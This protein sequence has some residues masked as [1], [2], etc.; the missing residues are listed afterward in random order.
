MVSQVCPDQ[1]RLAG[2]VQGLLTHQESH[3]L[4]HHLQ[5]CNACGD[6]VREL[7]A[8]DTVLKYVRTLDIDDKLEDHD[9]PKI[10]SLL[11][12]L[13][14]LPSEKNSSRSE[15]SSN[16]TDVNLRVD[17]VLR[18]ASPSVADDELGRIAHYRLLSLLG[19]GGMGVVFQAEDTKLQRLVAL[20]VLQ[21]CLLYTSPS[22][23]D[24]TLSRMPSS[25]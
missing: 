12:E 6:T 22:P 23:R 14:E 4:E 9:E 15:A 2:F 5:R 21:P 7:H 11:D 1:E 8:S 20:K 24:A 18:L 17:E 19:V 25:A 13:R 16:G 3:E 10:A